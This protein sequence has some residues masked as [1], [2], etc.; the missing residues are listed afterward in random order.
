MN[1]CRYVLGIDN[2]GTVTKA[3][4]YSADGELVAH[5]G[6]KVETLTPHPQWTER[7]VDDLWQANI[8]AIRGCLEA[9]AVDP[10]QIAS[11]SI[12]GH[13]NGLYL[14]TADG[15]PARNGIISTD[16]RAQSVVDEWLARDDFDERARAKTL[17][18]TWAG[19]PNALLRWLDLNEPEAF[20]ATDWILMVKDYIR[21]RLTGEITMEL[22]DASFISLMDVPNRSYDRELMAY[23]GI[24]RWFDKLPPIVESTGIGGRVTAE[25]A[26]LTGLAEGTPVAGGC[27][28]VAAAALAAGVVDANKAAAVTGTWSINEFV[29]TEPIKDTDAWLTAVYPVPGTFI[30]LDSSPNGVANL[31]WY[32][33]EVV[34][35]ILREFGGVEP[36]SA[37]IFATCERMIQEITPS[38][39]D[40][41]FIPFINGSDVVPHGRAG[42]IGLNAYHDIRHMV[43]AVYEGVILMHL[44]HITR[45]R[46]YAPLKNEITFTGGASNSELWTQMFADALGSPLE[47]VDAPEAGTLGVAAVGAVAGGIWPDVRTAVD[48]MTRDPRAVVEPDPAFTELWAKRFA[49]FTAYLDTQR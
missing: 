22:T 10:T 24:E 15:R 47:V 46:D 40:P 25:V 34:G 44:H 19:Q 38:D 36:D 17:S 45:L 6:A 14:S 20:E 48:K 39:D 2:G 37:K 23:W 11:V 26:S 49:R 18:T 21:F 3:C 29:S 43:R 12:T 33:R 30:V 32:L 31:E 7:N 9:A 5:Y 27:A 16:S 13:G 41:F 4:L 28:D 1:D 42:F 35:G 8:D